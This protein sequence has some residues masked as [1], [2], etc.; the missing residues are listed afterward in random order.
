MSILMLPIPPVS[1]SLATR[2]HRSRRADVPADPGLNAESTLMARPDNFMVFLRKARIAVTPRSSWL[3]TRLDNGT[4]V[5]GR[6]RPGYG[7]RGIY[8]WGDDI[9]PELRLLPAVL[10]P[11]HV[12][13]DVG[14]NVGVYSM[15]AA[16][17]VGEQGIV[18][19][20]E[21]F[22]EMVHALWRNVQLNGYQHVRIRQCCVSDA[23][24]DVRFWMNRDQPNS[25]SITKSD[26]NCQSLSVLSIRLD[27]ALQWEQLPRLDYLKIDAEGAEAAI[28]RGAKNSLARFRPIIQVEVTIEDVNPPE[29]YKSYAFPDSP[30]DG[31][32]KL[33]IPAE[34]PLVK[35]AAELGLRPL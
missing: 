14:A 3:T 21:P 25:F 22:P 8:L 20:Y 29:G 24:G 11:G 26:G 16:R 27:D 9:E 30:S 12:F 31:R 6:N 32:N 13:V 23:L 7:G 18:L 2:F 19:S 34:H 4:L 1:N 10:Q 35:K 33:L 15:Q 28:L 5:S 17:L